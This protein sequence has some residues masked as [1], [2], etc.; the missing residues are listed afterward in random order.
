MDLMI[1]SL[2]FHVG[3]LGTSRLLDPTKLG[4]SAGKNASAV[5]SESSVGSSSEVNSPTSFKLMES[6]EDRIEELDEIM[7]NL[8]LGESSG[9]SDEGSI[10]NLNSYTIMDFTTRSSGI[11]DSDEDTRRSEGRYTNN[12]HQM[13]V[14]IT[15]AA[16][17]NDG[18]NDMVAN[19]QGDNP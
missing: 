4:P 12:I 18:R 19:A 5:I 13:C 7:E 16:E 11:S 10:R 1:G 17:D 15:K 2:N 9:T 3:S 8:D 14:I 6:I